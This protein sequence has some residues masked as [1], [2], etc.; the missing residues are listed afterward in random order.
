MYIAILIKFQ[1]SSAVNKHFYLFYIFSNL[2][3]NKSK[4]KFNFLKYF[5]NVIY[6]FALLLLQV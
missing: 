2:L 4:K 3:F 1:I 5:L 6:V